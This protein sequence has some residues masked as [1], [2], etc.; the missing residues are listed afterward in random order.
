[1]ADTI[2]NYDIDQ[3]INIVNM[4]SSIQEE[5]T[6][7]L[8]IVKEFIISKKLILVG[9]MA[10]DLA[11]RLKGDTI[12]TDE[13]IPDYD[14]Y[15][16]NHAADAYELGSLLCKKKFTNVRV[17]NALHITTMRVSVDFETVADI[18]YCPLTIYKKVPVL[19]YDKLIIVHPHW[20]M[21]DQH[22]SLSRPF[23]N[24]GREVIF[25]RWKKDLE[26][27]DKLY[28]QYPV[29]PELEINDLNIEGDKTEQT[30]DKKYDSEGGYGIGNKRTSERELLSKTLEL[31]M[32]IVR[33]PF[34]KLSNSLICGWGSIDYKIDGD[35][36]LLSIPTDE[37]ITV[38]SDN[39]KKW[40]DDHNLK[41]IKYCSEYLG[42]VPRNIICSSN[43]KDIKYQNKKIEVYDIYGVLISAKKIS[44]KHDVW[45]CNIQYSMMFLLVKIFNSNDPKI[46]FT[47]EEQYLRC[48]QLVIEGDYPSIC[49]YGENNFTHSY[50]NSMKINKERI[51]S[52]KADQL[53]PPRM[54]PKYPECINNKEFDPEKSEY[55]MTDARQLD[56]FIEWTINP[57]PEYT[58][59]SI[60]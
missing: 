60:R 28:K 11:L 44:E 23:E 14:F 27:Y 56:K 16:P 48:R 37:P 10:I 42:K 55:F 58:N 33:V 50:L 17:I 36:I 52:I 29:V 59:K 45:V 9:G 3:Y 39:Y 31:P 6:R 15:S 5:I 25:H 38:A 2:Q 32:R 24:P 41:I 35:D 49:V 53:Q 30:K 57:Y 54:Y 18:T 7:A 46:V 19:K 13:Q 12:Y 8:Y 20:Q 40:I 1:M 34:E 4:R 47:A 26:R 51:Y 43:I 21:S 22:I